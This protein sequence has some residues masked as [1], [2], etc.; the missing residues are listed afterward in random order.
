MCSISK[1]GYGLCSLR[2]MRVYVA[3]EM[4]TC[5]RGL[6][7]DLWSL[8]KERAMEGWMLAQ[9]ECGLKHFPLSPRAFPNSSAAG[10]KPG[11]PAPQSESVHDLTLK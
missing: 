8:E 4:G 11:N 10:H 6:G 9:L 1:L 7:C 5:P 3:K 2:A